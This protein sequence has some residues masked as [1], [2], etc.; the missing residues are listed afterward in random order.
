MIEAR[1]KSTRII[2]GSASVPGGHKSLTAAQKFANGTQSPTP[3]HLGGRNTPIENTPNKVQDV[4]ELTETTP[5]LSPP[6][7]T[8]ASAVSD[9]GLLGNFLILMMMC[10]ITAHLLERVYRRC[11]FSSPIDRISAGIS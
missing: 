8:E 7:N 1:I 9:W 10:A 3:R 5:D 6:S 2:A 4:L 11:G